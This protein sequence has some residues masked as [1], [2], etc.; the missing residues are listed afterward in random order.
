MTLTSLHISSALCRE[1]PVEQQQTDNSG[2]SINPDKLINSQSDTEQL[3]ISEESP[4]SESEEEAI[5]ILEELHEDPTGQTEEPEMCEDVD[6]EVDSEH[7]EATQQQEDNKE[8][9][10]QE[11]DDAE[12]IENSQEVPELTEKQECTGCTEQEDCDQTTPQEEEPTV[13]PELS[14]SEQLGTTKESEQIQVQ[15]QHCEESAQQQHLEESTQTESEK[16]TLPEKTD[17]REDSAHI[18]QT[19]CDNLKDSEVAEQQEQMELLDQ[20]DQ[21]LQTTDLCQP[22]LSEQPVEPD[23]KD[24]S[25]VTE[26]LS[27][28][29]EIAQQTAEASHQ[30]EEVGG[31]VV[32]NG[33]Q[34]KPTETVVP[35]MNGGDVER[36]MA[37][38]LAEKLHNLDGIQRVDVVKHIDKE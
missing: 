19:V 11:A 32:A 13:E 37:R 9:S 22:A 30:P 38:H 2:R 8:P 17:K 16:A 6:E 15:E 14:E 20:N 25:E 7:L 1:A 12:K 3:D 29:T 34:P 31:T 28:V 26:Q 10:I 27:P 33:E 21:S 24:E 5:E 35:L 36:D 4:H 18:E 23:K